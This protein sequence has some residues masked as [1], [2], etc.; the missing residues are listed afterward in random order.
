MLR[1][2]AAEELKKEQ[3]RK[4]AERRR[5]IEE[6]CGKPKNVED[7]NE[8]RYDM[9]R[10]NRTLHT[11]YTLDLILLKF[12]EIFLK[13]NQTKNLSP[14]SLSLSLSRSSTFSISLET[15]KKEEKKLIFVVLRAS[16]E[17]VG[18]FSLSHDSHTTR[19]HIFSQESSMSYNFFPR[20]SFALTTWEA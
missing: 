8:G 13:K 4:A 5:I 16:S 11:L 14:F 1:K 2:K 15:R 12:F 18:T 3:E 9:F 19:L 17:P 20:F 10:S 7:A 6:R